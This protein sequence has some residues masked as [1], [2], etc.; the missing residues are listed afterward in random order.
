MQVLGTR[1]KREVGRRVAIRPPVVHVHVQV[2]APPAARGQIGEPLERDPMDHATSR[3]YGHIRARHPK[4][5]PVPHLDV[6]LPGGHR[7]LRGSGRVEVP[8]LKGALA[9]IERLVRV[10]P[11][12]VRCIG[13]P[14]RR[15]DRN[16]RRCPTPVPIDHLHPERAHRPAV[17]SLRRLDRLLASARH[18][19][20][21]ERRVAALVRDVGDPRP[22]PRPA[23]RGRI[24]L[25]V[26]E[27]E[28]VATLAG[29]EPQLI[30]L[31]TEIG[32]VH[33]ALAVR[34]PVGSGFPVGLLVPQL[35][36]RCAG[37]GGH[38]P[39][40]ACPMDVPAIRDQDQLAPVAGPG[41]REV[42][43]QHA[44]VVAG[45][46]A[47]VVVGESSDV[48]RCATVHRH[49]ED[50]PAPVVRGGDE[51]DPGAVGRP[52]RLHIDAPVAG[53]RPHRARRQL[54]QV[55]LDRVPGVPCEDDESPVGRP[56]GLVVVAPAFSGNLLRDPRADTLPPQ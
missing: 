9:A 12:V 21:P 26:G 37:G 55:Q 31:A 50:V 38:A 2:A 4:L 11:G 30:P 53:E 10:A 3:G 18:L 8:V 36:H 35:A 56:V 45:Q 17:A 48:T 24:E 46:L 27:G 34:R 52:A 22:I 39:E 28:R 25:P 14:V 32:A 42:V 6:D 49:C 19:D 15:G 33:D 43:I 7:Q 29:H 54:E 51:G 1:L 23:W 40:P 47:V 16:P 13:P 41:G 5:R 44:V 20:H